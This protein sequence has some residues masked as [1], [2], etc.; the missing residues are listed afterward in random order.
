[1]GDIQPPSTPER[2]PPSRT[3]AVKGQE[4]PRSD[5]PT[6]NQYRNFQGR[7]EFGSN[8]S[9]GEFSSFDIS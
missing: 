4:T 5:P 3:G 2:R 1:M 9:A 8:E 7:E 6:P